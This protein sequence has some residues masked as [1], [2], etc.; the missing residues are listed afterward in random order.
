MA[1]NELSNHNDL[2]LQQRQSSNRDVRILL[3][4]VQTGD[5]NSNP[6]KQSSY[7]S[8]NTSS[9]KNR[10]S[11][12]SSAEN[13]FDTRANYNDCDGDDDETTSFTPEHTCRNSQLRKKLETSNFE[14]FIYNFNKI[15]LGCYL[16]VMKASK[17][18]WTLYSLDESIAYE[19]NFEVIKNLNPQN[20]DEC[21]LIYTLS[22]ESFV[23][24]YIELMVLIHNTIVSKLYHLLNS[25]RIRVNLSGKHSKNAPHSDVTH[26]FRSFR[27]L[28]LR[29]QKCQSKKVAQSQRDFQQNFNLLN[30]SPGLI[31]K[32]F[33]ELIDIRGSFD[34]KQ[35]QNKSGYDCFIECEMSYFKILKDPVH[36]GNDCH[37]VNFN[38]N[39]DAQ[40]FSNK[41]SDYLNNTTN[42]WNEYLNTKLINQ[43]N[44]AAFKFT[45]RDLSD[46]FLDNN[47]CQKPSCKSS[48]LSSK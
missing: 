41:N 46:I 28:S 14:T 6:T 47:M 16:K 4:N 9:Y 13:E 34:I 29:H 40:R 42:Y 18:F 45:D 37:N 31:K 1:L 35:F 11:T 43:N 36:F 21:R 24:N 15:A 5:C 19:T 39:T 26:L 12:F 27:I 7:S 38:L 17:P 23:E 20:S 22:D 48:S 44:N 2:L 25:T 8:N 32:Q 30:V 3:Q 10:E 33:N